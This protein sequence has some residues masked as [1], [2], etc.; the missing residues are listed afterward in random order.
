MDLDSITVT[1]F[2]ANT[3]LGTGSAGKKMVDGDDIYLWVGPFKKTVTGGK[4]TIEPLEEKALLWIWK[5]GAYSNEDD[6]GNEIPE[7]SQEELRKETIDKLRED[8][9][10]AMSNRIANQSYEDGWVEAAP[11]WTTNPQGGYPNTY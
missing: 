4:V 11:E 7:E 1:K 10:Q 8:V 2:S 5:Y 3:E 6:E 9:A